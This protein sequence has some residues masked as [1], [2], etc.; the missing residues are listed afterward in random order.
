ME[1]V[2]LCGLSVII[3]CVIGIPIGVWAARNDRVDRVAQAVV[4]TL[5][6]M[7]AFA[8]LIP[9]VMLFRVG[10]FAA[11]LAV[12]AYSIVPVIRLPSSFS[13]PACPSPLRAMSN[14]CERRPGIPS[15]PRLAS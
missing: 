1:T 14:A 4:D 3:A 9:A 6:T 10:D 5:Q 15:R 7:P 8:Y 13:P 11:M 2:Y 12:V